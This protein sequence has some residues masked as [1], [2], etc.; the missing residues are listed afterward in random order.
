[1]DETGAYYTEWSKSERKTPIEYFNTYIR[2][3]GRWKQW[4]YTRDSKRDTNVKNRLLDSVEEGEGGMIWDNRI[5]T[6]ILPYVKQMNEYNKTETDSQIKEQSIS[7]YV[8][9]KV[10]IYIRW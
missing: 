6:C 7:F 2:H 4:P 3:L 9:I 5:E 10:Y 8:Y 1:M